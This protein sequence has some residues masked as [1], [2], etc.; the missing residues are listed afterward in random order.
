VSADPDRPGSWR[1]HVLY[2]PRNANALDDLTAGMAERA[3]DAADEHGAEVIDV[4]ARDGFAVATF[5]FTDPQHW[6]SIHTA[7]DPMM[8]DDIGLDAEC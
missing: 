7:M 8:W 5:R 3:G 6:F 1:L 2:R 4:A